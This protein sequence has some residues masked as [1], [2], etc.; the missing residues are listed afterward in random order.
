M[1]AII[2]EENFNYLSSSYVQYG[3]IVMALTLLTGLISIVFIALNHHKA[4]IRASQPPFLYIVIAG[5]MLS[6]FSIISLG[7]QTEYRN[8]KDPFTGQLLLEQNPSIKYVDAACMVSWWIYGIGFV[9][10]FSALCAKISR[11]K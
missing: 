2:P 10:T 5:C 4:I 6:I 9:L 1:C 11:I 7:V 8:V 3:Y